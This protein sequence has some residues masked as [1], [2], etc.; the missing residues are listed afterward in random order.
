[1]K[2]NSSRFRVTPAKIARIAR[3][4]AVRFRPEKVI[5]FGSWA[6][7]DARP[8]SDVDLLVVTTLNG[9]KRSKQIEILGALHDIVVA[10]DIVVVTPQE[11][12]DYADVVGTIIRPAVREGR[13]LYARS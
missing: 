1:M 12:A 10:T 9:T 8:D 6:R 2:R 3:R 5:L 4:I 11:F 7:G 13:V